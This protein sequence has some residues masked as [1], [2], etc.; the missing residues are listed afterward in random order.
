MALELPNFHFSIP[1][2]DLFLF[3]SIYFY[4]L[5]FFLF[6]FLSEKEFL[7]L[8]IKNTYELDEQLLVKMH[9]WMNVKF[10]PI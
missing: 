6:C 1:F 3:I 8:G 2:I 10:D 5:F 7:L 9:I 4:F